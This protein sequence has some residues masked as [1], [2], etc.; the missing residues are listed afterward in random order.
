MLGFFLP[1]HFA[2]LA[3]LPKLILVEIFAVKAF[4]PITPITLARH[5]CVTW[6]NNLEPNTLKERQVG[7]NHDNSWSLGTTVN[8]ENKETNYAVSRFSNFLEKEQF[9]FESG[10]L[11]DSFVEFIVN[12]YDS[13]E[14][15][16]KFK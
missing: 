2:A 10:E 8:I 3:P 12:G 15:A 11:L 16:T 1:R 7:N 13:I 6:A 4:P 14:R 5:Q 9:E